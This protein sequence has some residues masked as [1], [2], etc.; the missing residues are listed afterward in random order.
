MSRQSTQRSPL[1]LWPL[2]LCKINFR[3][4]ISDRDAV[5]LLNLTLNLT[6]VHRRA[7]PTEYVGRVWV[8]EEGGWLWWL[9][10][11]STP[12]CRETLGEGFR[13]VARVADKLQ[14]QSFGGERKHG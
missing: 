11:E 5:G 14:S 10:R 13:A 4:E 8:G 12:A 9:A 7:G 1:P 6:L 3:L 2:F